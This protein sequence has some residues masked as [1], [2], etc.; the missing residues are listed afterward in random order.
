MGTLW[1][2]SGFVSGKVITLRID[3]YDVEKYGE[4]DLY[5]AVMLKLSDGTVIESAQCAM[6][7]RNLLETLNTNH[8]ALTSQQLTMVADMI[9]KYA[10]ISTWKVENLIAV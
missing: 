1:W 7:M 9:K 6:T 10:I 4:T 8:T 3:N 2:R 5:A